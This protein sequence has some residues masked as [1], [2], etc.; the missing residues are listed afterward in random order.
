MLY[1]R[2]F[3]KYFIALRGFRPIFFLPACVL[4]P[5][6]RPL[7]FVK[8]AAEE[9]GRGKKNVF[10]NK[11]PYIMKQETENKKT[12]E[13]A[14]ESTPPQEKPEA[15]WSLHRK[16]AWIQA[17]LNV[18]KDRRNA[19]NPELEYRNVE[20]I[21][22][23]ARPLL[24]KT[25]CAL[26]F[27]EELHEVGGK[28]YVA[29]TATLTDAPGDTISCTSYA[30][31]DDVL[32]DMCG[33]Q[34]TGA[35]T[36]YARKYAAAGLLAIG[37]GRRLA[38]HAEIDA[39]DQGKVTALREKVEA[40]EKPAAPSPVRRPYSTD[41]PILAPGFGGWQEEVDR[42][43]AWKGTHDAFVHDLATRYVFTDETLLVLT[44]RRGTPFT[45]TD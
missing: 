40:G 27:S 22:A 30:R 11:K 44:S 13:R 43:R 37:S 36:S 34:V 14:A 41:L 1:F 19:A 21:C 29:A 38:T 33:A 23:A 31:E 10:R 15:G 17:R 39:L 18:P 16:L 35:C 26:M 32:P 24:E 2:A 7:R 20:D 42:V 25:G 9:R 28:T 3:F 4:S 45:G 5:L 12:P 8:G 6:Q